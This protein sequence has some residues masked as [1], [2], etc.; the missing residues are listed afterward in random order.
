LVSIVRNNQQKTIKFGTGGSIETTPAQAISKRANLMFRS[1]I[2][3]Q[4]YGRVGLVSST[5]PAGP[6][7]LA[8]L[9]CDRVDFEGSRGLCLTRGRGGPFNSTAAT[10]FDAD[11]RR[12]H[13]VQLAGYPS[14]TRVSSDGRYGATTVFVNGDSYA[15]TGFSTRTDVIDLAT[16]HILFGLE[17][18]KVQRD[19]RPFQGVDFNF[20]GVTFRPDSDNFYATLGTGGGTYLIEGNAITR[21]ATVLRAGVECPSLSPDGLHIAF[22]KRNPGP[23]VTWRISV[24]DVSTLKD[25]PLVETRD[26]DDQVA[27]LD[28]F[29]VSY[30]LPDSSSNLAAVSAATPGL[31]AMTTG[32]SIATDTWAVPADGHGSP[33]MVMPGAWSAVIVRG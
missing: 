7:S 11:F 8:A 20:W 27:W 25:H 4:D 16:G 18:L 23:V 28:N 26:V 3:N 32:S 19:G 5:Q 24:L 10:I 33:R 31:P 21:Q 29:T 22:K 12:L 14:R 9:R 30:G 17:K 6:R 1:T 13:T 15:A 2:L